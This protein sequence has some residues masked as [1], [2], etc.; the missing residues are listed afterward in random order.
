VSLFI[1][2]FKLANNKFLSLLSVSAKAI[3]L[4]SFFSRVLLAIY[5]AFRWSGKSMKLKLKK[6]N[7][8]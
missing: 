5:K 4:F 7:L 1:S 3:L 2:G 8:N 6:M